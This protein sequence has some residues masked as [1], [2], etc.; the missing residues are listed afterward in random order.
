MSIAAEWVKRV[1]YDQVLQLESMLPSYMSEMEITA[2]LSG[3]EVN[4]PT[5]QGTIVGDI[6]IQAYLNTSVEGGERGYLA[7]EESGLGRLTYLALPSGNVVFWP[8]LIYAGFPAGPGFYDDC[9]EDADNEQA[10][11]A[12]LTHLVE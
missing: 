3:L 7:S 11:L 2:H 6:S 10:A 4:T 1:P 5:L 9:I 8:S 12:L